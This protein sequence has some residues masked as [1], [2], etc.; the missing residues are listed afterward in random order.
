MIA[1]RRRRP[2][3]REPLP[4]TV[5]VLMALAALA[6][7]AVSTVHFGV[8]I[9]LGFMTISDSFPGAAP[10]ET[11]IAA[12]LAFGAVAVL[13]RHERSRGIALGTASFALLGTCYGLTIT[14]NSTRTG[15]VAYHLTMLAALLII[16]G[17]QLVPARWSVAAPGPKVRRGGW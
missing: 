16:L 10:P 2:N 12:V 8:D 13:T 14:L 4:V 11:V 1:D 5:G 7:G 17:L 3:P 6:F 9:Q 15:D